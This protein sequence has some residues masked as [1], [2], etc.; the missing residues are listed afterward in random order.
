MEYVE[1][2]METLVNS[3]QSGAVQLIMKFCLYYKNNIS[4]ETVMYACLQSQLM[5]E[6]L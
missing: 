3:K 2:M 5:Y 4:T 1:S 6:I